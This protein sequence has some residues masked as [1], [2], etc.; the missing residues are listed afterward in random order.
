MP[1]TLTLTSRHGTFTTDTFTLEQAI[2]KFLPA[3][4]N[5]MRG[6]M[7][8]LVPELDYTDVHY[9][10]EFLIILASEFKELVHDISAKPRWKRLQDI[11]PADRE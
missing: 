3:S 1:S 6:L 10:S 9:V 5:D 2:T 7:S 11:T 8:E 4:V